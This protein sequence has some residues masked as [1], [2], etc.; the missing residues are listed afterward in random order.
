MWNFCVAVPYPINGADLIAHY[1]LLPDLKSRRLISGIVKSVPQ[2]AISTVNSSTKFARILYEFPKVTGLEQATPN[3]SSDVRHHAER[4]RRLSPVK[5]K[6]A[7]AEFQ[8]LVEAG[9]CRLSSSLWASPIHWYRK[10]TDLHQAYIQIPVAPEDIPKTAVVTPFGLFEYKFIT[11]GLRNASQTFQLLQRLKKF[12]L[13]LNIENCEKGK[14]ELEFLGFMINSEGCKPTLDKA[15]GLTRPLIWTLAAEEAFNK[16][17]ENLA[18]ATILS[19]PSDAAETR[20][21]C[22]ASNFGAPT[23]TT[24]YCE[25]TGEAIRPYIPAFLRNR[26]F[27]DAAY[28]G[29]KVTDRVIHQRYVWPNM[30]RDIAKWY[31][32]CLDC[33]QSKIIRHGQLNPEK[34]IAPDGHFEHVHMDLIGPLPESDRYKYCVTIIDRFSRWPVAIPLEAIIVA[35][36]FYDNWV[37]NFGAPKTVTTDQ[38][39]QFEAQL[40]T[41]LL[42]LIGCQRIRTMAYH[43]T[44]NGMIELWH[45]SLKAAIMCHANEDWS[46]ELSTFD[47]DVNGTQHSVSVENLKPA[48]CIRDDLCNATPEV[49]QTI[50]SFSNEQPVLKTY[51][52]PKKKVTFAMI[53]TSSPRDKCNWLTTKKNT[54]DNTQ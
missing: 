24:L 8:R 23:H 28:P 10:K 51:A 43:P 4:S 52:R 46:R 22:D 26:V 48:Y 15:E 7:K 25:M 21:V 3:C 27:H 31:K 16:C 53:I 41:A 30:H 34:F 44:S 29:P 17:K 1:G 6:V 33:Q 12:Y 49:G 36:A 54:K 32:N 20:F 9:I 2:L 38:G 5:L 45:R 19:H 47:I 40:F 11:Y 50:N 42:Q 39:S 18:N 35:R 37:A 13:R 14:Q